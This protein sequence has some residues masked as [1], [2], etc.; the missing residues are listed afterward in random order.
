M[1]NDPSHRR[2]RPVSTEKI[3]A[4]LEAHRIGVSITDLEG[5]GVIC[6]CGAEFQDVFTD[7]ALIAHSAHQAAHV[8]AALEPVSREREKAAWADGFKQGGPMHDVNYDDPDAHRR[9]PYDTKE[10]A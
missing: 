2:E 8:A 7:H 4:V 9:N 10:E 1:P 5:F 6:H 3:A